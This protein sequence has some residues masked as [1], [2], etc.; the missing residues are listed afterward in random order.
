MDFKKRLKTRLNVAFIYI[1]IG[2]T[3]IVASF[4]MK[5][6]NYFISSWGIALVVIGIARIKKHRIITRSEDTIRKQQ[7]IETDE[8]NIT[9][10]YKARSAAFLIYILLLGLIVIILGFLDIVEA[11]K[12]ISYSVCL[13][14]VIY[15][16]CYMIYQKKM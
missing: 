5:T 14:I 3:S 15:W 13:L 10:V 2:I 7:I 6:D 9:I 4:I 8:R 1:A 16:G 12:W 11:A